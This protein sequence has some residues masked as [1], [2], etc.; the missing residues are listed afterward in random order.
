MESKNVEVVKRF[1][2]SVD[3]GKPEALG[4]LFTPGAKV[5]YESGDPVSLNDM[6]PVIKTFYTSFPDFK[7]TIEDIF[8]V[9][10]KVVARMSFSGTFRNGFMGF[11]PN[12][13]IFNYV[14]IHIFQF[15]D[16]RISTVWAVEDE[17]GLMTQLGLELKPK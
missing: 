17:L 12:G 9:G 8:E 16:G 7:H 1:Y 15:N 10:D 6:I 2:G 5:F 13:S 14:G 3:S 4:A 11:E